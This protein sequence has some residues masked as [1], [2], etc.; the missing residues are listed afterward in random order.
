MKW[1][2]IFGALFWLGWEWEEGR[3]LGQ[4]VRQQVVAAWQARQQAVQ[5]LKIK[6]QE[7]WKVPAGALK[8]PRAP[9]GVILPAKDETWEAFYTLIVDGVKIKRISNTME[10]SENYEIKQQ[11]VVRVFDGE[12]NKTFRPAQ[13]QAYP[14]GYISPEKYPLDMEGAEWRCVLLVF[15]PLRYPPLSRYREAEVLSAQVLGEKVELRGQRCVLLRVA[16]KAP[17]VRELWLDRERNYLPLREISYINDR[18]YLQIDWLTYR[19]EQGLWVPWSW[20]CQSLRQGQKV[21]STDTCQALEVEVNRP[22]PAE[23]FILE[24]PEGTRVMD[25]RQLDARGNPADYIIRSGGRKRV[26]SLQELATKK[27]EELMQEE[28]Q[29]SRLWL[30][31]LGGVV[32][33]GLLGLLYVFVYRRKRHATPP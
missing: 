14:K 12:M 26:I 20:Q 23:E 10:I 13:I 32:I 7:T 22:I 4:E 24:F 3:L 27:Y 2:Y 18:P 8:H 25:R 29:T 1:I 31:S 17:E 28:Q 11:E 15:W 16:T 33:V 6:W 5:Q 9:K 30:W 21:L 19:Q